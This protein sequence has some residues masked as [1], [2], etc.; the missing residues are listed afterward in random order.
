MPAAS[1][2]LS[3]QITLTGDSRK[4]INKLI[5]F[6]GKENLYKLLDPFMTRQALRAAGVITKSQL[7]GQL[8]KRRTGALARSMTGIG[9]RDRGVPALKVGLF[10]GP[11]LK[12]AAV[13][14]EGTVGK[15]G[16]HPTI[17]PRAGKALAFPVDDALTPAGVDRY[18]GPRHYPG[19]LKFIPFR[20][21]GIA[22]GALYDAV[23]LKQEQDAA[24]EQSRTAQLEN[25]KKLYVLLSHLDLPPRQ[26]LRKGFEEYLPEFASALATYLKR[27]ITDV[28]S[29]LP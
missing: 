29:R 5:S 8:L 15:G 13:L 21:S 9:L 28:E 23:S 4:L 26:Y 20:R 2:S 25:V 19:E 14:D 11:A 10:R 3:L 12:Y 6:V 17:V 16:T 7:S 22:V 27:V 24:R 18:G 1:N